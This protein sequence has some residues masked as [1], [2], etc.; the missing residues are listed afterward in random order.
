ME[1]IVGVIKSQ[2][3]ILRDQQNLLRHV[4]ETSVMG[5]NTSLTE[6][7]GNEIVE[8]LDVIADQ[9][10][11][12]YLEQ[13]GTF[14]GRDKQKFDNWLYDLEIV[15]AKFHLQP[16]KTAFLRSSGNLRQFLG[17]FTQGSD[18]TKIREQLIF[19]F[20]ANPTV[21][22]VEVAL[23]RMHQGS[24]GLATY[25]KNYSRIVNQAVF[26]SPKEITYP[27]EIARF[28]RSLR[29][30]KLA[31]KVQTKKP[32]TLQEAM[33]LAQELEKPMRE[34]EALLQFRPSVLTG[35]SRKDKRVMAVNRRPDLQ[36]VKEELDKPTLPVARDEEEIPTTVKEVMNIQQG[37]PSKNTEC[38]RCGKLGHWSW[39]CEQQGKP[40]QG[41]AP[42]APL[43]GRLNY[44][45]TG[46]LPL[47]EGFHELLATA[48]QRAEQQRKE[49]N[50]Y[51]AAWKAAQGNQNNPQQPPRK[52][53][54]KNAGNQ[55]ATPDDKTPKPAPRGG[56][57]KFNIVPTK[58]ATKEVT[59]IMTESA[60]GTDEEEDSGEPTRMGTVQITMDTEDDSDVSSDD[61]DPEPLQED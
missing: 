35:N 37:K 23:H 54:P 24:E 27:L 39:Q 25:C 17:E 40:Q 33:T 44:S 20:S 49:K 32:K 7:Q 12:K 3:G 47:N 21:H 55:Q 42:P 51:K 5:G 14:D 2:E 38:Y 52:F 1:T 19:E 57:K 9:A 15:C 28:I 34:R 11:S 26:K 58:P 50:K 10:T 4:A 61:E 56:A 41:G 13:I 6:H 43:Q 60:E 29:N 59:N 8:K 36:V 30:D 45:A 16:L 46:S 22:H 48:F 53:P 18:W 31:E